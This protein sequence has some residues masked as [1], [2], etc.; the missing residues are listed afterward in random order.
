MFGLS[1]N[2]RFSL[3]NK[4]CDMRK[5]FDG[6]CGL[7]QNDLEVSPSNGTV[8][9]LKPTYLKVPFEMKGSVVKVSDKIEDDE[10]LKILRK[11]NSETDQ[12]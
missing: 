12:N 11:L 10:V 7:V 8:F 3:Y 1:V 2:D 6:L 9:T 4:P 5:S